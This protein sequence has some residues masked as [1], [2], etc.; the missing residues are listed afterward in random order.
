MAGTTTTR[1]TTTSSGTPTAEG[2]S[3]G[4][5]NDPDRLALAEAKCRLAHLVPELAAMRDGSA[6]PAMQEQR[7]GEQVAE[8]ESEL[9]RWQIR[10]DELQRAVPDPDAVAAPDGS[11]PPQRRGQHLRLYLQQR[12]QRRADLQNKLTYLATVA[13]DKSAPRDVRRRARSPEAA[14]SST[15]RYWTAN[16]STPSC[17]RR[18]CART[19]FIWP[20]GTAT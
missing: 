9:A 15:C 14:P 3:T 16:P 19:A 5:P 6:F 18:T 10:H 8:L 4:P 7:R 17:G 12:R 11:N 1:T 2:T 20:L 13:E